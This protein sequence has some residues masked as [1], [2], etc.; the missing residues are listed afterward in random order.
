M[1][2][3]VIGDGVVHGFGADPSQAD[4]RAGHQRERP[5]EAPAVAVEHRQRPQVHRMARHARRE[6]V[7][8]AH[9]GRTPMMVDDALRIAGGARRVIQRDGVPF[10]GG[11]LP[12]EFGVAVFEKRFVIEIRKRCTQARVFAVV[13]VDDERLDSG[14]GERVA[15]EGRELA[16]RDQ[17]LGV[18]VIELEREDRRVEARVE[19]VQYGARHRDRV[20]RLQHGRRVGQDDRDGI[21]GPDATARQGGGETADARVELRVGQAPRSMNDGGVVRVD[22]SCA[23]E[24][25]QRRERLVVRRVLFQTSGIGIVDH[26]RGSF[27][28]GSDAWAWASAAR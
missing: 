25:A 13:A 19:A 26:A 10:V 18:A 22:G 8:I 28:D 15:H 23:F 20:V 6:H 27:L 2:D 4:V 14:C 11:Q 24:E 5:G 3:R 12:R 16:I 9:Q 1:R 21:S 7:R 17:D